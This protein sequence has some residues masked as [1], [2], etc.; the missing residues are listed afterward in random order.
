MNQL[1]SLKRSFISLTE[2]TETTE[3]DNYYFSITAER[4]A[5]KNHYAFGKCW[6]SKPTHKVD[7]FF[8]S[9]LLSR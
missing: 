2:L 6:Q 3:K 9:A 4:T 7:R 1:T 5:N 8:L